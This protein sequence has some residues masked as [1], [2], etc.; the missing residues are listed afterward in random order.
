MLPKR[1]KPVRSGIPRAPQREW[2]RHRAWVRRHACCVP[3][4]TNGPIEFAHVRSSLDAGVGQKPHDAYGISLCSACHRRQH[5][6][7][8]AAFEK[9]TGI[10]MQKLAA[11]FRA[12]SPDRAMRESFAKEST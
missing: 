3:H 9:E 1:I 4:C 6:V 8:E 5:Q 10:N 12:L 7:G 2:P 11:E